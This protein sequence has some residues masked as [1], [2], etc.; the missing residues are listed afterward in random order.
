MIHVTSRVGGK[1]NNKMNTRDAE[2]IVVETA[3][4]MK[5]LNG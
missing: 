1:G 2:N 3:L 5:D 4:V